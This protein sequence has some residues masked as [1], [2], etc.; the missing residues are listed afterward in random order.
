VVQFPLQ[1]A[2][3]EEHLLLVLSVQ[4][5]VAR[6]AV[7][8]L[9]V[10]ELVELVVVVLAGTLT[11]QAVAAVELMSLLVVPVVGLLAVKGAFYQPQT[12]TLVHVSLSLQLGFPLH[13]RRGSWAGQ[14]ETLGQLHLVMRLVSQQAGLVTGV[15]AVLLRVLLAFRLVAQ[16]PPVLLLLNGNRRYYEKSI[17][18]HASKRS[19]YCT[20]G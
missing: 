10:V 4:Q 5:R 17:D 8:V 6:L 20:L 3:Q 14:Q 2:E 12:A 15:V 16:V 19:I 13:L 9:I 18:R 7:T 11:F 1:L